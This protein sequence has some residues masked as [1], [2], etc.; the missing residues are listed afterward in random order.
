MTVINKLNQTLEML[1]SS[2]SNCRTFSMDT[3]DQNAKQMFN[4]IADTIKQAEDML[5]NRINY[6]MSEEPQYQPQAQQNQAKQQ[7]NLQALQND[8]E[9]DEIPEL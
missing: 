7:Q 3:D 5:Q 8:V 4:Q 1:K 6:V 2:E 9:K